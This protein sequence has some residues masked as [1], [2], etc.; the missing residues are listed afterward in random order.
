MCTIS[1][2]WIGRAVNP[3]GRITG[4]VKLFIGILSETFSSDEQIFIAAEIT[5]EI[6]FIENY[7]IVGGN[8]R[9]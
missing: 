1:E 4:L 5:M 8:F 3:T 6:V 2:L 7:A 9:F